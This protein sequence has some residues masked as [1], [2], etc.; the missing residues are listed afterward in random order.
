[1]PM[2]SHAAGLSIR[3]SVVSLTL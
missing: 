1:M 3:S 2:P